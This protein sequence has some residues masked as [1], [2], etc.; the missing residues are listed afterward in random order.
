MEAVTAKEVME[1]DANL[2]EVSRPEN[3]PLC[4]ER[5]SRPP[6]RY[7]ID[8]YAATM[9]VENHVHNVA[10]NVCQIVEPKTMEEALESHHTKVWKAEASLEYESHTENQTRELW[11]YPMNGN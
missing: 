2:V 8:E 1:V 3:E 9:A 4:S 6:V 5:Q 7:G 11:N 10:Y